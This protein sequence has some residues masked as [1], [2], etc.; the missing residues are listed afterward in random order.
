M[1]ENMSDKKSIT[2]KK[3]LNNMASKVG[4]NKNDRTHS[5]KH[6]SCVFCNKENLYFTNAL[7]RKE[8]LIS[9]IC[10]ECQN[11]FFD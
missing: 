5:I 8:F 7:S 4:N 3:A 2:I 10:E 9:G 6:K 1:E 11:A